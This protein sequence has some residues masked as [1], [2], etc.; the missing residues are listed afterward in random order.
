M[1]LNLI[2][3][4]ETRP[5]LFHLTAESNVE[6]IRESGVLSPASHLLRSAGFARN[7]RRRR[8][9]SLL[10]RDGDRRIH[11]RDQAPL[12]AGNVELAGGWSFEDLVEHL[13]D[14]V[15]FWPGDDRPNDYGRRHFAR[16]R[17]QDCRVLVFSTRGLL[18]ANRD[19]PPRLCRFNSGSPRCTGGR[20]SPRGPDLFQLVDEYGGTAATVVEVVFR[21]EVR[22]PD[23]FQVQ[24]P[25]EFV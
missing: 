23:H 19:L 20:R 24:E 15:F 13:N 18:A 21:G 14:H 16:Y 12:H 10:I 17:D 2:D 6:R 8:P 5:R 3:F 25:G 11:I 9:G 22:L 7:I 1:T 4:L